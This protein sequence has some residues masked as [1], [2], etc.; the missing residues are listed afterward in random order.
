MLALW[1][2]ETIFS[3]MPG[4]NVLPRTRECQIFRIFKNFISK[5]FRV[6]THLGFS[7]LGHF[8]PVCTKNMKKFPDDINKFGLIFPIDMVSRAGNP[9]VF[10]L[11][12]KNRFFYMVEPL[13]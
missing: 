1:T 5:N 3:Q 8:G 4:I 12:S 6:W 9:L 7:H 13:Y 2:R 10:E 11:F